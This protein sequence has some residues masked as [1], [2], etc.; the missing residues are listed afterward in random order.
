M[1]IKGALER[2]RKARAER[3]TAVLQCP[4]CKKGIRITLPQSGTWGIM[5]GKFLFPEKGE[6]KGL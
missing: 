2:M 1:S 6:E 3:N 5:K 4:H